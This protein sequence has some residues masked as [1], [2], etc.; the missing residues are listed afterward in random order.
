MPVAC[1][2]VSAPVG[3]IISVKVMLEFLL[4]CLD[5]RNRLY[6]L[7]VISIVLFLGIVSRNIHLKYFFC[8]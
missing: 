2:I 8:I 7:N 1:D 4:N 6:D 5:V 3:Y